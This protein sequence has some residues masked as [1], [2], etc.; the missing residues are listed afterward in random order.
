M[1][2]SFKSKSNSNEELLIRALVDDIYQIEEKINSIYDQINKNEQNN[3]S[4]QKIEELRNCRNNLIQQKIKLN[5]TLISK[6]KNNSETIQ[7]KLS[8]IKDIDD[9][10]TMKKNELISNFNTLSFKSLK[11]KNYILSNKS[12]DF[13]SEEQIN[14]IILDPSGSQS[15]EIH[16][17]K[18]EIAINK[19]SEC[20]II[21]NYNE[22][23]SKIAQI[24]ENLKM[25]KEEK[26]TTKYE[27]INLISCKESLESI[28]KLN[29]NQ[30]NIHNKL[31]NDNVQ[32]KNPLEE[33]QSNNKW[34][35]PNE[36]FIYELM[37][38][39]SQKAANNICNQLFNL[40]NIND[41]DNNIINNNQT[42]NGIKNRNNKKIN[43]FKTVDSNST[44]NQNYVN[45]N[46]SVNE[47]FN[48]KLKNS[49]NEQSF[50]NYNSIYLKYNYMSIN[51]NVNTNAILNKKNI[52]NFI[53]K[54]LDKFIA[55]E[56]YSYKTIYEFLENLSI[57]IISKFQYANIIISAD[58]LTIYLSYT[59]KSLYYDS[60]INSKLQFINK[61]YKT[62]K[63]NFKKLIPM[64]YSESS[65][66]DTK[67][68]EYKSKIQIIDKQIKLLQKENTNKISKS[69]KIK[70]NSEEQ[71]YIQI[72][73]KA[74]GLI[75]QK[76]NIE[77]IIN[78]YE[79]KKNMLIEDN[80]LMVS[81]LNDDIN[82]IDKEIAQINKEIKNEK[83]KA[84]KD[85]DYYKQIIN[86]KYSIINEQLQ[87]Y[88]D[89]YGS[90][91]DIYNRLIN[92]INNTIKRSHTKQP[93]IIINNNN[94][95]NNSN[96]F[97]YD[98]N[99]NINSNEENLELEVNNKKNNKNVKNIKELILFPNENIIN[100]ELNEELINTNNINKEL[101]NIGF[102][103]SRI[104]KS[105]YVQNVKLKDANNLSINNINNI[106]INNQSGKNYKSMSIREQNIKKINERRK[107][108]KALS[109]VESF[110]R[111]NNK[112]PSSEYINKSSK[113]KNKNNS[114]N[115]DIK[116]AKN[117]TFYSIS[118]NI[119]N[120]KILKEKISNNSM[121][122]ANIGNNISINNIP[123]INCTSE[124]RFDKYN[125]YYNNYYKKNSKILTHYNSNSNNITKPKYQS[126]SFM[127]KSTKKRLDSS[128]LTKNKDNNN[129]HNSITK[130]KLGLF[131]F[132]EKRDAKR[133]LNNSTNNN[134]IKFLNTKELNKLNHTLQSL[135]DT[136]T[137]RSKIP[138]KSS[139]FNSHKT[140][141]KQKFLEKM[142]YLK[143]STFCYYREYNNS[144]HKYNPLLDVS[145]NYIC[146]NPY[147]FIQANIILNE[148][149][150]QIEINPI[151]DKLD[152]VMISVFDIENTI[153][154]SKI[155]SIIEV[156]RNF[157]KYKESSKFKSVEDFVERQMSKNPQLTGDEIEK[158]A[159]NKNFNFSLLLK[160]GRLIEL[161]IC[162]YE[163][164]KQW[165][166]GLAFLI[167][168]KDEIF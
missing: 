115:T 88:K 4:N 24:E 12:N 150:N 15:P 36:L 20:V 19:A 46:K 147:N 160:E 40:F 7:E 125:K 124:R 66:L 162:S 50:N 58:T 65:K 84:N 117:K 52:A 108:N 83:N 45:Q 34:T 79:N 77:K 78:E 97:S 73:S 128:S 56:I 130:K 90:N 26:M 104:E 38:I 133:N 113:L 165:I 92:S 6:I 44:I 102:D 39:D 127:G 111:L 149:F 95:I 28:I 158:C 23:K 142:K 59:F 112:N 85:I 71:N 75:K 70:L 141:N 129:F 123:S 99:N 136:I 68:H 91:L 5:D 167:K 121:N 119:S 101:F 29:I 25:L 55:G 105:P 53:Q 103:I 152:K 49:D 51:G 42:I 14:D 114:I 63:K 106:S 109:N 96:I 30:L 116:D 61:D 35:K 98:I 76:K 107:E 110:Y 1:S 156:H 47:L 18:R 60:I 94:N 22:I 118:S 164:F 27:L 86:E 148:E 87:I 145:E 146:E 126:Y 41:E 93:L 122:K 82:N 134:S 21:N 10:I 140:H 62:I 139:N 17:L 159:K 74:N 32:N 13:L 151:N 155:K 168:N 89:K 138:Y 135:K 81:K 3:N 143:K 67:Y 161:I 64:L 48:Y 80:E 31:K 33:S 16:K 144:S 11:L 157:R 57:I 8:L 163:E 153:V 137:Q 43:S 54:E 37:V 131:C 120:K 100:N 132:K 9:N 72:C 154:S 2:L 69:K 166:N